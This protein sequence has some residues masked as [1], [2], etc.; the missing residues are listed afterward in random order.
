[1]GDRETLKVVKQEE[2]DGMLS[3]ATGKGKGRARAWD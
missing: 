3:N 2:I 1:M